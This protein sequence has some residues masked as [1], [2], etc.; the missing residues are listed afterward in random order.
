MDTDETQIPDLNL[1]VFNLCPSVF[2]LTKPAPMQG[3]LN[4]WTATVSETVS[5]AAD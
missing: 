5:M 1:F 2:K 4:Q 3:F